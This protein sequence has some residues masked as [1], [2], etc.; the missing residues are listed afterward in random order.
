MQPSSLCNVTEP[1]LAELVSRARNRL[2][3]VAPGASEAVACAVSAAWERLGAE[4]VT[5][6]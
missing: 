4:R 1:M 6:W 5:G 3:F 2:V